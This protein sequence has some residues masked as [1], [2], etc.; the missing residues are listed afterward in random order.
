MDT[1]DTALKVMAS[2][3]I[4][5]VLVCDANKPIGIL[6]RRQAMGCCA[7]GQNPSS[8]SLDEVMSERLLLV[9][10][11][12][13]IDELGVELMT[14]RLQHAVVV[15][16]NERLLGIVSE[17][18]I[19]NSQGIEH[20]LFLRSVGDIAPARSLLLDEQL[21]MRD[22]IQQMRTRE[23]SAALIRSADKNYILTETDIIRLLASG[24]DLNRPLSSFN[25]SELVAIDESIS[26]YIARKIFR[27]HGFRHLG[28]TDA[29]ERVTRVLSY[30][31]ILRSV[32]RDYVARLREKLADRN[33]ALQQSMHNLRLIE[34]V[35]NASME[36][37]LITDA[38]GAIQ[39]VNPAFTAITGYEAHEV[40]GRNPKLLS[41]GRH[42]REFYQNM[43][44]CLRQEGAWQGEIWNRT[45]KGVVF[46]EWLSI[47]A[48]TDD[49][50]EVTQYAAIFHDLTEA[51]RSEARFRQIVQFDDLTQLANRK[52]FSD[53]LDMAIHYA[54][55]QEQNFAVLAIDLDMFKRIN[56]RF[57]HDAGDDVIRTL[58][59]R[60]EGTLNSDDT[61]ARPAGDEFALILSDISEEALAQR[62]E[63][64]SRV[65]STPVL[66]GSS[67]IR[68]T[69]SIGVA[70]YPTDAESVEQLMRAAD[71]AMHHAKDLGRNGWAYFSSEMHQRRQSRYLIA[72]QL[73]QAVQNDE[74]A[75]VYQ[76]KLSLVNGEV[77]GVE[78]LLR[79]H[80]AE[81]GTVP[82][83]QFIPLAEDNG[84]IHGIG[85]WVLETAIAQA[86]RWQLAGQPLHVAVNLS[87]RQFQREGLVENI[88]RLLSR[89]GLEPGLLCV[90][91]TETCFLH[92]AEQTAE[93]LLA[94]RKSGVQV[95]IDDFGTGYSS[96]SYIRTMS[97]DQLKIDRSFVSNLTEAERDRQLVSAMI[98]MSQALGLKVVAEGVET[99]EQLD[100]L[101]QLGCDEAQGFLICRP[102]AAEELEKVLPELVR[103]D[104]NSPGEA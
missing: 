35:I 68:I 16:D 76:P 49:L 71:A 79:W 81:L 83:D 11:D 96:L 65:I 19:V 25:L 69:A 50:G 15:D 1:L 48:I 21:F 41:S 27:R 9:K 24:D 66:V 72:A 84:L 31:D 70:I 55:E 42:D 44:N 102:V 30:A 12:T 22:A 54:G 75:L 8:V 38:A 7:R 97:L 100:I 87:A 45:K 34:R 64:L 43:W 101:Q 18:D 13:S 78:A 80:N 103:P 32:E 3:G 73:H 61:V 74:L 36:G 85:D 17:S 94:L 58:A 6:T 28:L 57:G 33:Q 67:E 98:A 92:S 10:A 86:R 20:D 2:R 47:T 37:V 52:L 63:H 5:S 26:L 89:Y 23:Q 99:T 104:W 56:D 53:R 93:A 4:G 62:I 14:R 95:S 29:D 51:K 46:P 77:V 91:L 88:N 40:V 82:P 39:S 59:K 60:I 90:E